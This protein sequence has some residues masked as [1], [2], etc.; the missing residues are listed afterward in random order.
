MKSRHPSTYPGLA[1]TEIALVNNIITFTRQ[2]FQN[3]KFDASHDFQHV[4]RVTNT[5][6]HILDQEQARRKSQSLPPLDPM[7]VILGAL[8]H[9]VE[10][11]KYLSPSA[12]PG[13]HSES[14]VTCA[15]G[16]FGAS[17]ALVT[18]VSRL[19]GLVSFSTES[20]HP[21]LVA[22]FLRDVPELG[23]VQDADRIDAIGSLGIARCFTYG[24]AKAGK[25][26]GSAI[27]HFQEK[28]L[29]LES[30]MKTDTG[31]E[32][33]A[34]RSRRIR[35]FMAWWVEEGGPTQSYGEGDGADEWQ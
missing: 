26:L 17:E 19:V 31:Q 35:E 21:D 9:D 6:M 29:K 10:D 32:M 22:R 24:G 18:E 27:E 4:M 3:P 28:L 15:L 34:Q 33:A 8:L 2:Y 20:R 13:I 14:A 1:P 11:K 7:V 30:M 16:Q 5:A 12:G 25:G 23:I